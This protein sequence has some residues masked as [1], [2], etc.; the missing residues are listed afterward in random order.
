MNI[1][2]CV[3]FQSS[4]LLCFFRYILRSGIAELYGSSIFSF[5]RNLH[6]IF[7]SRYTNLHS[8]QQCTRVPFFPQPC[9]HLLFVLFLMTAIL[10]AV[11]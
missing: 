11:R 2:V 9:Q 4:V 3:S 10:T 5:L 8:Y 6:T 1:G 7:H